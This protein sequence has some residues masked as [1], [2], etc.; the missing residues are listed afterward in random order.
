MTLASF[1]WAHNRSAEPM[2]E[3]FTFPTGAWKVLVTDARRIPLDAWC[4]IW[5]CLLNLALAECCQICNG[6]YCILESW[7]GMQYS[8]ALFQL[9]CVLR[10]DFLLDRLRSHLFC[11]CTIH[12]CL[13]CLTSPVLKRIGNIHRCWFAYNSLTP[14]KSVFRRTNDNFFS[15]L[16]SYHLCTPLSTEFCRFFAWN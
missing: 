9:I 1:I 3:R 16:T 15:H 8:A 5:N 13:N 14:R 2:P 6:A 7:I 12:D 10:N 4:Q 11:L